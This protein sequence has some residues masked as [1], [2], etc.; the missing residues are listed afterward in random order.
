MATYQKEIGSQ[1]KDSTLDFQVITKLSAE[2]FKTFCNDI[3]GMFGV[4]MDCKKQPRFIGVESLEGLKKHFKE[5]V[6]VHCVKAEGT[7]EDIFY[8]VFDCGGLFTLAG[9]VNMHPG[10]T[11]LREIK[12]GTLESAK[13]TSNVLAEVGQALVGSWDG[14]VYCLP[15]SRGG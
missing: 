13:N 2:S 1:S 14:K 7:I 8:L 9:V 15:A 12:S 10:Q 3:S 4:N 6:S 11:M 5:P